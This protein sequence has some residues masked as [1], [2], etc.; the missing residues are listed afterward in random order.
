MICGMIGASYALTPPGTIPGGEWI[1]VVV[2][3]AML[4]DGSKLCRLLHKHMMHAGDG[5]EPA[6][7]FRVWIP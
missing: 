2:V 7:L 6:Y 3:C 5:Y 1:A 4:A